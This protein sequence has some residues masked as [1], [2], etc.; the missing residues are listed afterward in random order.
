MGLSVEDG[1]ATLTAFTAGAVGKALDILPERGPTQLI[2]CGGG[3]RNPTLVA[4]FVSARASNPCSPRASDGAATRSRPNASRSSRFARC[5]VCRSASR[6]TTG[7]KQPDDRR[8]PG[9]S[10]A[11]S[12]RAGRSYRRTDEK[13][14]AVTMSLELYFHPFCVVLSEGPDRLLRERHAVRARILWILATTPR[15]QRSRTF[16]RSRN[17]R[18]CAITRGSRQFRNRASSSNI[19]RNIIPARPRLLPEEP[20]LAIDTRFWD[21]FFDLLCARADAED[22]GRQACA[23]RAGR[24][25][26]CRRRHGAAD[27]GLWA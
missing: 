2:V 26:R 8:P 22:R 21:R 10:P 13:D 27:D 17:F 9:A 15:E 25:L 12:L 19:W 20:D 14:A 4:P 18:F 3:R 16:G 23:R 24:C 6:C 5:A 7:V 1:A 11:R